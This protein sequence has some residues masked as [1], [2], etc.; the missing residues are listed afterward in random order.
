MQSKMKDLLGND[1]KV[2]DKIAFLPRKENHS[3]FQYNM[4]YGMV[5]KM[6]MDKTAAYCKSI[7]ESD[8]PELLRYTH[9]IIKLS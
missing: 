2:G 3:G 9:Q 8:Y 1:I 6:T 7:S 4:Q 5:T